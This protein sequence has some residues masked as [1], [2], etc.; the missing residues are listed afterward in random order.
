MDSFLC[1]PL[2]R[3]TKY[4]LLLR[5]RHHHPIARSDRVSQRALATHT[6]IASDPTTTGTPQSHARGRSRV[7][8]DRAGRRPREGNAQ[9]GTFETP[10]AAY[11]SQL[12]VP[13]HPHLRQVNTRARQ[14]ERLRRLMELQMKI[15]KVPAPSPH[16]MPCTWESALLL[17]PFARTYTYTHT[18]PQTHTHT[19]THAH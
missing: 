16:T 10:P 13:P 8:A 3:M 2:Q 12:I 11:G 15:D 17:T 4:P 9:S 6:A 1:A 7:R 14:D 19:H 5:V 18:T